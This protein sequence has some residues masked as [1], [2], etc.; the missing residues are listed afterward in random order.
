MS[1]VKEYVTQEVRSGLISS[2]ER[3]KIY[4][5]V[6]EKL[7]WTL[8]PDVARTLT[9]ALKENEDTAGPLFTVGFARRAPNTRVLL[10]AN[11]ILLHARQE[12]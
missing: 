5:L 11:T 2:F 10:V 3:E 8:P 4:S 9:W 7:E 6:A 12:K 1:T